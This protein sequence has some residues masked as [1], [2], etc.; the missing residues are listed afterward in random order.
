MRAQMEPAGLLEQLREKGIRHLVLTGVSGQFEASTGAAK[1]SPGEPAA[2]RAVLAAG[3]VIYEIR[4]ER[5]VSRGGR[6]RV[7]EIDWSGS[8]GR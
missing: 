5:G 3:R 4:P 2:Y 8:A 7:V 1:A 6:I